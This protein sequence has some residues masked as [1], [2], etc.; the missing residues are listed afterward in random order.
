VSFTPPE[1]ARQCD[2]CGVQIV[3]QPKSADPT[4]APEGI[5]PF[6]ITQKQA[7][8]GLRQWLKSRWFAP[9]ALKQFAQPEAIKGST[10]F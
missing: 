3:A 1:V 7:D 9:N 5:L 2:F 4:L 6:R 8:E 10:S